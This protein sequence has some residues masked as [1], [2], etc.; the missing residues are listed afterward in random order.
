MKLSDLY[1]SRVDQQ[2]LDDVIEAAQKNL[3]VWAGAQDEYLGPSAV[4]IISDVSP[5]T[6]EQFK[7]LDYTSFPYNEDEELDEEFM[8]IHL[9]LVVRGTRNLV[10]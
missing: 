2:Y 4:F 5:I 8:L 7:K 3:V 10:R 9:F 6:K 1:E